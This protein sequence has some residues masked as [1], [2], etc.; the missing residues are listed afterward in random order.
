MQTSVPSDKVRADSVREAQRTWRMR[1]V[2]NPLLHGQY[3]AKQA[4][5]R[6]E[7]R[8]LANDNKKAKGCPRVIKRRLTGKQP[9]PPLASLVSGPLCV[10][11]QSKIESLSD[12]EFKALEKKFVTMLNIKKA[13]HAAT[14]QRVLDFWAE[15]RQVRHLYAEFW[16]KIPEELRQCVLR[17]MRTSHGPVDWTMDET[18]WDPELRQ[19]CL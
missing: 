12:V 17:H 5:R 4:A 14:L 8:K 1:L 6:K 2:K 13:A 19:G 10:D 9:L 15:D 7:L 11:Q 18:Y 16:K 3:K